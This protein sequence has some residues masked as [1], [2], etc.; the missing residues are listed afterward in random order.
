MVSPELRS[1]ALQATAL[2]E[3]GHAFGLWGHSSVP[4]DALAISQGES[5]VLVPSE[6]DRLTLAWV[7]QQTTRFG[8]TIQQPIEP[9][10]SA[11]SE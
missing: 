8:S 4:T 3:L 9:S 10:E 2:H 7:M 5:P 11:L 6:R 1:E